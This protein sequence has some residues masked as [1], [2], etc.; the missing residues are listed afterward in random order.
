MSNPVIR[1]QIVTPSPDR[2]SEFYCKLFGWQ[3]TRENML[4]YQIIDTGSERGIHGGI[5]PAPPDTP[6][7]VQ[8]SME[9]DN[10]SE[11]VAQAVALGASILFPP[12]TLPDGDVMAILKD[13]TGM[14]FGIVDSP[15]TGAAG[16]HSV[17]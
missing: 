12:Q 9:V 11:S 2:V 3:A 13:P 8:L 10:C 7:F 15:R 5:W 1:W 14:T 16:Q 6:N 4:N 17:D